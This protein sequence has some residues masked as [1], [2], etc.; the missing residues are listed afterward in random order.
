MDARSGAE[1]H[2]AVA[3]SYC[4]EHGTFRISKVPQQS[5]FP[6]LSSNPLVEENKQA[7]T[8]MGK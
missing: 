2:C 5:F 7:N 8:S 1:T 3:A 4:D 6:E